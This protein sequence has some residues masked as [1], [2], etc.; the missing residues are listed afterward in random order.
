MSIILPRMW[1]PAWMLCRCSAFG[2]RSTSICSCTALLRGLQAMVNAAMKTCQGRN[3]FRK[4]VCRNALHWRKVIRNGSYRSDQMLLEQQITLLPSMG[5]KENGWK[6]FRGFQ[7]QWWKAK[8]NRILPVFFKRE[9]RNCRK[10]LGK[11]SLIKH[12]ACTKWKYL[13]TIFLYQIWNK[14][15]L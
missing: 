1:L 13:T 5:T 14:E 10:H 15:C 7:S 12:K 8:K 3:Y 6:N 11:T 9:P 2:V 4:V